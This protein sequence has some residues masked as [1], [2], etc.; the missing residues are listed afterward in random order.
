MGR[1]AHPYRS[2]DRERAFCTGCFQ[3]INACEEGM[4]NTKI[5]D[6][7]GAKKPVIADV[8]FLDTFIDET[9]R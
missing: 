1:Y 8:K 9:I 4:K 7:G 6:E 3:N 2:L 5:G